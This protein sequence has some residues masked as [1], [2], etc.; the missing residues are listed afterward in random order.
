MQELQNWDKVSA[1]N[2]IATTLAVEWGTLMFKNLPKATSTE[3]GTYQTD[4][5]DSMLRKTS[6]HLELEYL[7]EVVT[8][9]QSRYGT[10]K[11]K[12][13]DVNRY[14]RLENGVFDDNAPSLPAAS[15]A[16]TFGQLPSFVSRAQNTQ[17]RYGYSGNSF[18]AAVEF[19]PKVK[20]KTIETGGTSF[21]PASKHFTDQ[22]QGY[23]DGKFKDVL[24]YKD[25]VL[26]HA[27]KT[28]HPGL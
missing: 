22:A 21:D 11:V 12:W 25:D 23:L 13:G 20:A 27:E 3:A 2:S 10:W 17:K 26:K 14:Q 24:F 8:S 6:G 16:S 18:I 5:V 19:G 28:Y 4:R 7:D 1:T 9:L 15:T